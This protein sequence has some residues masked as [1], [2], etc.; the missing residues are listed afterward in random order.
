MPAGG[1]PAGS[2]EWMHSDE[3]TEE[4]T[5]NEKRMAGI[6]VFTC[7]LAI[8]GFT[9]TK[10]EV[11]RRVEEELSEEHKKEWYEGTYRQKRLDEQRMREAELEGF[12]AALEESEAL[13][14]EEAAARRQAEARA[15]SVG[16]E[17]RAEMVDHAREP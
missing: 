3:R 8:A 7:A 17:A 16:E 6:A 14:R 15:A 9:W 10:W 5:R 13:L 11:E 1:T 2:E 12:E 4:I